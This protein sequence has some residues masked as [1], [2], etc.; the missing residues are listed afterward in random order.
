MNNRTVYSPSIVS[1]I[2]LTISADHLF[3]F[4]A[5]LNQDLLF[6]LLTTVGELNT[7]NV[8]VSRRHRDRIR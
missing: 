4:S 2:Y 3:V 5:L 6:A 1:H 7:R 8:P